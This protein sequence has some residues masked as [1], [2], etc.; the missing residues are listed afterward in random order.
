MRHREG[1]LLAQSPKLTSR[2]F[3]PGGW[4]PECT[5]REKSWEVEQ[6]SGPLDLRFRCPFLLA[7]FSCPQGRALC[8][9]WSAMGRLLSRWRPPDPGR[10]WMALCK[11]CCES[12][13]RVNP[14]L[15]LRRRVSCHL[16][17]PA[18]TLPDWCP[19][20]TFFPHLLQE[21]VLSWDQSWRWGWDRD[22]C[23]DRS[24]PPCMGAGISHGGL[25][26]VAAMP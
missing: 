7:H 9:N 13:K 23:R 21:R 4:S 16:P 26:N 6:P 1:K 15:L 20:H 14:H 12:G 11:G 18:L 24:R 5:T 8:M 10:V 25:E 22:V 19:F 3:T 2:D 17:L